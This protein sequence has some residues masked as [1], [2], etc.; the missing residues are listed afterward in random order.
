MSADYNANP[1]AAAGPLESPRA[2]RRTD[3]DQSLAWLARPMTTRRGAIILGA[4]VLGA[5]ALMPLDVWVMTT[6][7]PFGG[8]T[9]HLGGDVRRELEFAQQ[10]GAFTSIVIIALVILL[11]DR[12]RFPRVLDLVAGVLANA[13]VCNLL[14]MAFGRPR[15]RVV[16]PDASG[17]VPME[18][19]DSPHNFAFFWRAFPLPRDARPDVDGLQLTYLWARSWEL[20]KNISSDL[21]SMPSSHAAA[22]ACTAA[23]LAR[24]YPRLSPLLIGLM[25]VVACARVVFG[26]HYPSDVALGAAVGFVVGALAMEGRWI[27]RFVRS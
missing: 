5:L 11:Q 14:K 16:F 20:T 13:L 15:P 18:G 27:S 10:F 19:F 17:R 7:G 2:G 4:G 21:W 22:A 26:A 23:A 24:L 12:P 1:A 3:A 6:I 9:Q 25:V 8:I